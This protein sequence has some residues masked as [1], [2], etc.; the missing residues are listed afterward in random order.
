VKGAATPPCGIYLP[1]WQASV[2]DLRQFQDCPLFAHSETGC[3]LCF[4]PQKAGKTARFR[5]HG[6][7][8][9][10]PILR[11]SRK[12]LPLGRVGELLDVAEAYLSFM[13]SPFTTGKTLVVDGGMLLV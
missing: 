11:D 8:A 6:I 7:H 5:R 4:L 3:E 13:R 2:G 12:A 1:R 9:Q 10:S